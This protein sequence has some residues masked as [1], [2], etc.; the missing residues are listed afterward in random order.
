[1][2]GNNF[3]LKKNYFIQL[4]SSNMY[5]YIDRIQC[6]VMSCCHGR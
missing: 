1:M 3:Q 4:D 5:K 6:N 2:L